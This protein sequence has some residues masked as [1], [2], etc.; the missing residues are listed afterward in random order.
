MDFIYVLQFD[1]A[2]HTGSS[3]YQSLMRNFSIKEIPSIPCMPAPFHARSCPS[4]CRE[5]GRVCVR[6]IYTHRHAVCCV[7]SL[8]QIIS[9]SGRSK[10]G[11]SSAMSAHTGLPAS[12]RFSAYGVIRVLLSKPYRATQCCWAMLRRSPDLP[13]MNV[14]LPAALE[15]SGRR[16]SCLLQQYCLAR[17]RCCCSSRR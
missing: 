12:L 7:S 8:G 16:A 14:H 9:V 17:K 13:T 2:P 11:S 10:T 4:L 5:R 3:R 6:C 1:V 15:S